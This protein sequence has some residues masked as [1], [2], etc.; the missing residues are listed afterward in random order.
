MT[1]TLTCRFIGEKDQIFKF[2]HV[3]SLPKFTACVLGCYTQSQSLLQIVR[4]A[5]STSFTQ[6]SPLPRPCSPNTPPPPCHLEVPRTC[7]PNCFAARLT[8]YVIGSPTEAAPHG[9]SRG[10]RQHGPL[11]LH[12]HGPD[13]HSAGHQDRQG[14]GRFGNPS[15]PPF[16][17]IFTCFPQLSLISL[18]PTLQH[19]LPF[20][21][22]QPRNLQLSPMLLLLYLE[23]SVLLCM[24]VDHGCSMLL[25]VVCEAEGGDP[26]ESM[27]LSNC[28]QLLLQLEIDHSY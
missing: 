13:P 28:A 23:Y 22:C 20:L 7:H 18:L 14:Y 10:R 5:P 8:A 12:P 4:T 26:V 15:L 3:L 11:Q 27:V 2:E 24:L 21:C 25:R 9:S 19:C 16:G 1:L 17:V 6:T